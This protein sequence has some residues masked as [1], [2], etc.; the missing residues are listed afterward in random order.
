MSTQYTARGGASA[1]DT[2]TTGHASYAKSQHARP[3]TELAF[4]WLAKNHRLAPQGQ[5]AKVDW[6][7]T[8]ASAS[9]QS[10]PV[11]HAP[12]RSGMRGLE[13]T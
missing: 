11:D 3:R 6:L 1:L 8:F 2:R 12:R 4:G 7:V 10:P 5:T 9:A 13:R